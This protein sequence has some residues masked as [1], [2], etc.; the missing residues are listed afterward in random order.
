MNGH[1]LVLGELEDFLTGDTLKDTHDER[2][3]QGLARMLIRDK[4]YLRKDIRPRTPL[5]VSVD[6]NKAVIFIDFVIQLSS[7]IE[8]IIQYSPGSIVTRHR[9]VMAISRLLTP[10]QIPVAVVTNGEEADVLDAAT[11]QTLFSGLPAIPTRRHLQ[12]L[13]QRAAYEAITPKRAEMESRILYAYEVDGRCP[14]DD[15]VCMI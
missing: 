15:T 11:G 8:M 10:Y 6:R 13:T 12:E 1:H 4:G 7:R 2:Y 9:P 5:A 14:C 3:R